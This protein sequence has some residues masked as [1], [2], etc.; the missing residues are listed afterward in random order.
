[1]VVS[2]CPLIRLT[3]FPLGIE[4]TP[5]EGTY[6]SLPR[7][8]SRIQMQWGTRMTKPACSGGLLDESDGT[9]TLRYD[10]NTYNLTSAQII[11]STHKSWLVPI[12]ENTED[13]LFI[14]TTPSTT[15]LTPI[16]MIIIPIV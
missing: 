10:T 16:I 15:T 2:V 13:I 12:T 6:K 11:K 1:M 9:T 3:S 14:F 5:T 7:V 8:N 4:F